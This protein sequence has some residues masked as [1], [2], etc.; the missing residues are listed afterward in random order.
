MRDVER[1]LA[2]L[3]PPQREA[4]THVLGP[5]L[6]LAGAGSGKT[7]VITHRIAYLVGHEGIDPRELVAVTFTNKAAGEMRQRAEHLLG[8]G[9]HGAYVGT[10]HAFGLRV[11]RAHALAAGY[12]P[13]FVVYDSAD[14]LA[15]VRAIIKDRSLDDKSFPPR[16]VLSWISKAKTA[17][18]DPDEA[19]A[20]ARGF[21][22]RTLS[23]VYREYESRLQ[24]AGAMDFDDL[25]VR[26]IRLFARHPEIAERYAQ[27]TRFLL[28]DEYQDT[29]QIQ[30]RLIRALSAQ[31]RN[32]C[33]V[34]DEDQSI[35][36]F[37]GADIRNILDFT[38]DY[39]DAR[40]V[41]L[42]QNYRSTGNILAA[43][44]GVI[45]HNAQRHEKTLWTDAGQG[46]K[47]RVHL[48]YDDRA[49]ADFV[50]DDMLRT[51]R[52]Q[53]IP[54]EDFAILYRTNATSRLLEDRLMARNVPYRVVGSLR[55]WDRKEIKDL[56]AW[57]RLL[58]HPASDQDFLRASSTPPRGLGDRTLE[59]VE[60]EAR[61]AGVSLHDATLTVLGQPDALPSRS[62]RALQAFIDT[63]RDLGDLTRRTSTAGTVQSVLEAIDFVPYLQRAHPH[64]YESRVENLGALVSAAKEHDEAG[65]LNGL[66]GFLDRVSLR[67]DT[68]DVQG[69]RGP[70]LMTIHAAK[71]L[72]FD[73]LYVVGMNEDLFP[74]PWSANDA[75]GLEEER[76]LCYV[77]IT[78]ARQRLVLTH[79]RFRSTFGQV[80]F[81]RPSRFLAELPADV[82]THTGDAAATPL[83]SASTSLGRAPGTAARPYAAASGAPRSTPASPASTHA[84]GIDRRSGQIVYESEDGGQGATFRVGMTVSHPKYGPGIVMMV[85]GRAQRTFVTI[86]FKNGSLKKI[87]P[88]HTTLIPH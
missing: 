70:S 38:R 88:A 34:G 77:A 43:A 12:P 4:V 49:E 37:R 65:A 55:F 41:K 33:A 52:E 69:A 25:L 42:E 3:N 47:V 80:A 31:H 86:R 63:L 74:H 8:A 48:A 27:R 50:V 53:A 21:N 40:V 2:R 84:A 30:Y 66:A 17:L 24:R 62:L 6:I 75:D 15:I 64:D 32:V 29:N 82:A 73:A 51:A 71:G 57:L 59:V 19:L 13:T 1:V 83:S 44:A 67:S 79:A 23:D 18:A 87:S 81:T 26:V 60:A 9:L 76:R 7:R 22:E 16:Q 20:H 85:E 46:E 36:A 5:L 14:Q 78:R 39:A 35:Y 72:E 11:L 54:L 58:V 68:D 45:A 28:V 56:L 10:F 61:R